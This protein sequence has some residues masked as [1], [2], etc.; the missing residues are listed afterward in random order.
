MASLVQNVVAPH[1]AHKE[2]EF[3]HTSES[4][5]G[6]YTMDKCALGSG[7]A[8]HSAKPGRRPPRARRAPHRDACRRLGRPPLAARPAR[9][10]T[11][12]ALPAKVN[13]SLRTA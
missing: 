2:R 11:A 13:A 12:Q 6:T 7:R 5:A 8:A 3:L 9:P 1:A 4:R 10:G